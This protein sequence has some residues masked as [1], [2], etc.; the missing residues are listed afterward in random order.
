M[1]FLLCLKGGEK[2]MTMIVYMTLALDLIIRA[3]CVMLLIAGIV[4]AVVSIGEKKKAVN[5]LTVISN[6]LHILMD[7][8]IKKAREF[9]KGNDNHKE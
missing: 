5:E 4:H 6:R 3:L 8:P 2:I 9:M 7:I 1:A